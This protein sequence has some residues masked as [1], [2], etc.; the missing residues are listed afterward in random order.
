MTHAPVRLGV[1]VLLASLALCTIDGH[2]PSRFGVAPAAAWRADGF[3]RRSVFPQPPP[4]PWRHWG[5]P[6][7]RPRV[8][9]RPVVPA[10]VF[11]APAPRPVWI[12]EHWAWNGWQWVWIPAHWE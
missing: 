2:G 3:E 12:A 11:V 10:P 7:V 4:D 5:A 8:V 9:V 1:L 6:M